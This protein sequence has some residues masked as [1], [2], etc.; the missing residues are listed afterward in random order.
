[1]KVLLLALYDVHSYG[2][3][4]LHA[5]L[6]KKGFDVES[7]FFKSNFLDDT[8]YSE[9]QVDVL[10]KYIVN[11]E[12]DILGIGLRSPLF[13]LFKEIISKLKSYP[14]V[15]ILVGG[16]HGTADP[17]SLKPYANYIHRGELGNAI[18]KICFNLGNGKTSFYA[19]PSQVEDLD[20]L[21]FDYYGKDDK[22]FFTDP[23]YD[24]D[25][26]SLY[27]MKGCFFG[28]SFCFE[29]VFRRLYKEEYKVRRKSV[30]R[31]M[32]EVHRC[33]K[34]FPNLKD[35]VF[36]DP[37]FT[38]GDEWMKEF[39]REFSKTGLRFRCFSH[40]NLANRS[41]LDRLV[42]AGMDSVTF[43]IQSASPRILKIYNR[44]H[45]NVDRLFK[46]L[47]GLG[48]TMRFDFIVNAPFEREEDTRIT[49]DFIKSLPEP[50]IVRRLELRHFLGTPLTS[51]CLDRGY[52][53]KKD[54]EGNKF[55][56]G[57]GV[58]YWK[59]SKE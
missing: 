58:S 46:S 37:I 40:I 33:Q 25:R 52:I 8:A 6:K 53:T 47:D 2:I 55:V 23:P 43:G 18:G 50:S 15:K 4:G 27:A 22:Y 38:W 49:E 1:M 5:A 12:P 20:S 56:Y 45:K 13:P 41:M 11:A 16:H 31:V 21:E 51:Y 10:V 3:R 54:V 44:K 19:K 29:Q 14:N 59:E 48:S 24:A 39:S 57:H 34:L 28:C 35:I 26:I 17:G 30:K 9:E 7:L 32:M 36:S 42:D